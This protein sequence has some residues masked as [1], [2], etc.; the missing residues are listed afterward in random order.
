MQKFVG[1]K[2]PKRED[3]KN[4]NAD[5]L[6]KDLENYWKHKDTNTCKLNKPSGP[7]SG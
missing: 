7:T 2:R 5:D 4:L 3:R 1:G 6:D